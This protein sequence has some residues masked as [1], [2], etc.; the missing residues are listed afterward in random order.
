MVIRNSD[1]P[2]HLTPG[3]KVIY[4]ER[5]ETATRDWDKIA[6][7]MTS[8]KIQE[9]YG[10]LAGLSYMKRW[11]DERQEQGLSEQS[12]VIR[13]YPAEST[14]SVDRDTLADDLTGDVKLNVMGLADDAMDYKESLVFNLL[15]NGFA[16]LCYDGQAFFDTTHPWAGTTVSNTQSGAGSVLS[17]DSIQTALVQMRSL[18]KNN[19][20]T[21]MVVKPDTLI[22]PPALE[23]TA[24]EILN[25][26]LLIPIDVTTGGAVATQG[27]TNTMYKRIANLIVSPFLTSTTAWFLLDTSKAVRPLILQERETPQFVALDRPDSDQNFLKRKI[28]YGVDW[29]GGAGYAL[30]QFAH[31][32]AGA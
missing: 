27:N 2:Q 25:S 26:P 31:G 4:N 23:E 6:T 18:K 12:F 7:S 22:V 20:I 9:S 14:I 16:D 19:G 30:W 28:L 21:P 5:M 11:V 17:R 24:L 15:N 8:N 10:F 32:S 29:R 3:L 1:I 13:N